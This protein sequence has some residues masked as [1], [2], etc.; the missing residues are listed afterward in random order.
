MTDTTQAQQEELLVNM[1]TAAD[2]L[3]KLLPEAPGYWTHYLHN[4]RRADRTPAYRI[5]YRKRG[6]SVLYRAGDV[7][8][9]VAWEKGR[10]YRIAKVPGR[11]SDAITVRLDQHCMEALEAIQRRTELPASEI[12]ESLF[13]ALLLDLWAASDA[14]AQ[15]PEGQ[16]R[17]ALQAWL[18]KRHGGAR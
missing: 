14:T 7:A 6:R 5:P 13:P 11:D 16:E 15:A 3:H 12:L 4:N 18:E 9:F 8:D 17:A 10:R 1:Q 2:A